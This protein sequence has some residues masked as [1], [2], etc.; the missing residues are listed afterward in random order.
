MTL[1][2][3]P[4]LV[5]LFQDQAERFAGKPFLWHKRDGSWQSWSWQ[6]TGDVVSHLSRGLSALGVG[7]GDRV[8]LLSEN[9]PEWPA[10]DLAIMAT[11][12]ITVPAYCTNTP[13][14]HAHILNDSGAKAAIVST[15]RLARNLLPAAHRAADLKTVITIEP[16]NLTQSL[17]LDVHQWD[18]VLARGAATG[19]AGLA[20]LN[21]IQRT[22][23]ACI[24]YTSGTGGAPKGVMLS[25]GAILHNVAG[26]RGALADLGLEQEKFL[27]FLPLSHSYEHTAGQFFPIAIGAEIYYAEG[28]DTLLANLQEVRPTLMTAVP[29]LYETMRGRILRNVAAGSGSGQKFFNKALDLGRRKYEGVVPL[30]LGERLVDSVLDALVR[31][32]IKG[33][34]GG[35]LKAM[36]SGGAPL[37]P[38]IGLFFQSLGFCIL[39]GYGQTESAP[40]VS[41][42]RPARPQMHTVGPLLDDLDLRIA[43]DGEILVRGELVMQGYW[44]NPEETARTIVDGWLHTG[45]IGIVD[46]D[47]HLR[48]TDRKN[49]IIVNSGGDN[50]SP[51]R[52][53]GILTM[54]PEIAQAMIYGDRR[55]HLVAL[56]VPDEEWLANWALANDQDCDL[57]LLADDPA[58][59]TALEP[60]VARVNGG[61]SNIEKIRRFMIATAPFTIDNEQLTP[62]MKIRRHQIRAI[63]GEALEALYGGAGAPD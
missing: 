53:E 7:P 48:I 32:K 41:V 27:S 58:L 2:G 11:G 34:F 54:E 52:I 24:I 20:N 13:A 23:T 15:A 60:S 33:R 61:L 42:N 43:D 59:R 31:R 10:A 1:P 8:V 57:A 16:P 19:G 39:Q 30:G 44:R 6:F 18:A 3:C 22:D 35:R 45:D 37:N 46:A 4:N 62:T 40:I 63:Y 47:G 28:V 14:D 12:A 26:A 25:H 51:Q 9:R 56:L 29:R 5:A 50:V 36:I 38:E 21:S 17:S 55:P 49:D